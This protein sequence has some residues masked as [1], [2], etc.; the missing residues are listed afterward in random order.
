M[1]AVGDKAPAFSLLDQ[2]GQTV[3]LA[4]LLEAGKAV[5]LFFYPKDNTPGCTME[6]KA[7][8]DAHEDFKAAGAEVVGISRDGAESHKSFCSKLDLQ[9]RLLTDANGEVRKAYG[10]KTD[11]FGLLD[12]R[13]TFVIGKDGLVKLVFNSQLNAKK[14]VA[15]ALEALK[16]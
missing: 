11:L 8:R 10:V 12:G 3:T 4:G 2:D 1:V 13:W 9:F 15:Q 6:A 16:A 14:H 5:V 7:F